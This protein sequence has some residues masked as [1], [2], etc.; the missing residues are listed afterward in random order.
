MTAMDNRCEC[1]GHDNLSAGVAS[2]SIGAFSIM[3]C[4]ICV[5]LGAEPKWALDALGEPVD[6]AYYDPDQDRYISYKTKE[7][8]VIEFMDGQKF[9]KRK[10]VLE[11]LEQIAKETS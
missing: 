8:I 2:S 10:E 4:Q 9:T 5:A 11:A 3:W 7:P 1:C 6:V